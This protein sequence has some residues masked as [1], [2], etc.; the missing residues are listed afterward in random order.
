MENT[1]NFQAHFFYWGGKGVFINV[2]FRIDICCLCFELNVEVV[3]GKSEVNFV[4]CS[5]HLGPS[6]VSHLSPPTPF[7][8]FLQTP[9]FAELK[10]SY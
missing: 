5:E 4:Q 6:A 10:T 7:G 8:L 2:A 1:E 9:S 3:W